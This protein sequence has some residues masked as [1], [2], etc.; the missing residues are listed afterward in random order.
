MSRPFESH[1]E[2][3]RINRGEGVG[4]FCRTTLRTMAKQHGSLPIVAGFERHR[5]LSPAL[6]EP[7]SSVG[8][9]WGQRRWSWRE[10]V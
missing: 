6:Q 9:V 1:A 2:V 4:V 5:S 8:G 7:T 3:F 10:S